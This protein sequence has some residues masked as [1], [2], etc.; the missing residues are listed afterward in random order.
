MILGGWGRT[1]SVSLFLKFYFK[2]ARSF[3]FG[4]KSVAFTFLG[5]DCSSFT[6]LQKDQGRILA[7]L[8]GESQ[9]TAAA[10]GTGRM[11]TNFN[12]LLYNV[13]GH[14]LPKSPG[15][16]EVVGECAAGPTLRKTLR[17]RLKK[18]VQGDPGFHS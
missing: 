13:A 9:Q 7:S 8:A 18:T 16:T 10:P 17:G 6:L 1:I 15:Q 4:V 5:S 11:K 14:R 12:C 2:G 3:I